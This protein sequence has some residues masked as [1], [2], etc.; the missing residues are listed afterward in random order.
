MLTCKSPRKVLRLAYSVARRVLPE[1]SSRFSR[2][3]FTLAQLFACLVLRE[4]QKKSYRGLEALLRDVHWGREIG[5][6]RTPDHNTLCRAFHAIVNLKHVESMLMLLSRIPLKIGHF[7]Q[8]LDVAID[9][10]YLDTHH[11]SRH[12]EMRCRHHASDIKAIGNQRRS[13][14]VKKTPKLILSIDPSTHGVLAADARTGACGDGQ[15]F[16]PMLTMTC[17]RTA[18]AGRRVARVLADAGFDGHHNHAFA[19]EELGIESLIQTGGG[20]PSDKTP[21]SIYRAAMKVILN[22]SQSGKPY[23]QRVQ[24]ETVNSMIKRNLGDSLRAVS[25]RAREMEMLLRAVVHNIMI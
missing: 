6:E 19:R 24:V 17:R 5:M 22:G 14:S 10:T 2:H 21:A 8:N 4:H 15:H 25:P 16:I 1:F 12:Y 13:E 23:G 9:S 7:G 18:L 3:D 11:R 20:R